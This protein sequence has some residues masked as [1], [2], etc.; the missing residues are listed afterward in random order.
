MATLSAWDI[1][2]F[3][4]ATAG[5]ISG[6]VAIRFAVIHTKYFR[7]IR[8]E[9]QQSLGQLT[10]NLERTE[11]VSQHAEKIGRHTEEIG[12]QVLMTL[13]LKELIGS[14]LTLTDSLKDIAQ[15]FTTVR[16]NDDR[17]CRQLADQSL[18]TAQG[19]MRMEADG[20]L[21]INEFADVEQVASRL[22]DMANEGEEFLASSLVST[23]FWDKAAYYL[24]MH[25][26]KRNKVKMQRVF[27]FESKEAAEDANAQHQMQRHALLGVEVFYVVPADIRTMKD[28]VVVRRPTSTPDVFDHLYGAEFSLGKNRTIERIE[29]W[30][31]YDVYSE[32]VRQLGFQ[33]ESMFEDPNTKRFEVDLTRETSSPDAPVDQADTVSSPAAAPVGE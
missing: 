11:E 24:Q 12:R 32:K 14:D 27:V 18:R 17:L 8:T 6:V 10:E 31:G 4:I 13:S 16:T 33:L 19:Q 2:G 20:H 22:L 5:L 7:T 25:S 29:I 15:Q 9:I 21:I 30:A 28:L 3:A 23:E 1:S 26:S